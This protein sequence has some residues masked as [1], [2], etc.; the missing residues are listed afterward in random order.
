MKS[1]P[2]EAI[3]DIDWLA[4]KKEAMSK[5]GLKVSAL[6]LY[7]IYIEQTHLYDAVKTW[8]PEED[9]TIRKT[10]SLYGDKKNSWN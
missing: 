7:R 8:T 5:T 3:E 10:V 1:Y 4:I 9:E 2:F 6:D